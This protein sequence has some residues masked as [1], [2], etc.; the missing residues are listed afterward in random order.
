MNVDEKYQLAAS[1]H[2]AG[3]LREAE[4]MYRQILDLLPDH[5]DALHMLGVISFQ[6][7][8]YDSAITYFLKTIQVNQS[9]A[10]AYYDLGNAYLEKGL[11]EESINSY[12]KALDIN[13]DIPEAYCNLGL[14]LHEKGDIDEAIHCYRKA[15]QLDNEFED[16]HWNLSHA[17]LL[18]GIFKEGW[19]EYEWRRTIAEYYQNFSFSQPLWDGY[20]IAGSTILIHA[21]QGF[22]DTLQFIRYVASV[23]KRGA[24]TIVQC[25]RELKSLLQ[26]V[27]GTG[28]VVARDEQLPEFDVHY[29]LL[30]LPFLFDT[31]L[32]T[33]PSKVPYIPAETSIVQKWKEFLQHDN[34]HLKIG[35]VWSSGQGQ[36][37]PKKSFPLTL[38]LPLTQLQ[39]V[40][41]YSLQK[42]ESAEQ[43]E[44]PSWGIRIIDYTKEIY[45]FSDT[46]ALIENLDLVI[47]V[48]TAVAH[49]A[50][51]LGKPV[52]TLLPFVP[53]WRW[54]L[55]RNDSPW[56]PTMRLFRQPSPGDWKSVIEEVSEALRQMV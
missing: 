28:R 41:F 20:D 56:Y 26:G 29:P 40:S 8:E 54:M 16:A 1:Y 6:L 47:S 39:N 44:N 4:H 10:E 2:Q 18:T 49:L 53:D 48:D 3:D 12:R 23:A 31:T 43:A 25:A 38:F 11:I 14:V 42:G 36:W 32:D 52:W 50:G 17:L 24:K 27:E 34:A 55:H 5:A 7:G 9:S 22:G 13:P 15:I 51:A 19:K 21:E 30:S 33:I 46:A 45:D 35:L 37:R